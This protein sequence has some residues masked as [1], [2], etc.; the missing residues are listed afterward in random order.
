[1]GVKMALTHFVTQFTHVSRHFRV[2]SRKQN[3]EKW[4]REN[5]FENVVSDLYKKNYLC[6]QKN[7]FRKNGEKT[8]IIFGGF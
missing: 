1:M 7:T 8:L 2:Y 6:V 4:F 5:C 3:K